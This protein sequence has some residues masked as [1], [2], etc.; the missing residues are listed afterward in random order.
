MSDGYP[1]MQDI[2]DELAT[3]KVAQLDDR[4]FIELTQ[5][6]Y[7]LLKRRRPGTIQSFDRPGGGTIGLYGGLPVKII[8]PEGAP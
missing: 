7:D 8:D 3:M 1:T 4:E 2:L 5:A 6:E